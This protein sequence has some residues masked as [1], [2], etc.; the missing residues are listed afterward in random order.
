MRDGRNWW[1]LV[2]LSSVA[3]FLGGCDEETQAAVEDGVIDA[4]AS[5]LASL[6]QAIIQLAGEAADS[7]AMILISSAARALL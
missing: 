1:W 7:S 4:S 5:L 2:A 3:V 6:M